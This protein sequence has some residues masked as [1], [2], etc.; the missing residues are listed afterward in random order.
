MI[1]R[2][3]IDNL[4]GPKWTDFMVPFVQSKA[5]EDILEAL[6]SEKS[7]G[8]KVYPS[9]P[10]NPKNDPKLVFRAFNSLPLDEVRVVILGQDPYPIPGYANG[11]AFA[12]PTT[13]KIAPSLEKI[14]DAIEVDC[15]N[16]LDFDKNKFDTELTSW[17]KQGVM[18]LNTALTVSHKPADK[19]AETN[20]HAELWRPFTA[21]V[22]DTLAKTKRDLIFL[23]WG[24][25]AQ[26]FTEHIHFVQHFNFLSEHPAFAA[27]EKRAWDTHAF[28]LTNA[29]IIGNGLGEPIKW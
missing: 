11:L 4:F 14:I 8:N 24:K 20:S 22:V 21:Y 3:V 28:S 29:T 13:K 26:Q 16:G 15:Y 18:L 5:F 10:E 2:E 17:V 6:K 9:D 12:H 7:A 27:R 25:N 1:K 23:S 19:Y